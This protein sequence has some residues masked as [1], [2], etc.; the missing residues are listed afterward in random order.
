MIVDYKT[1]TVS[2]A[3]E[4]DAKLAG[5]ELQGAAYA[6]ALEQSVGLPVATCHFVFCR[7]GGAIERQ[8]HDLDSAK[9]RV[10][11][12]LAN[13]PVVGSRAESGM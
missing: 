4:V 5:Y 6:V 11:D 2:S 13:E 9:A 12:H 10:I 1:D 7:P 3:A 8:I